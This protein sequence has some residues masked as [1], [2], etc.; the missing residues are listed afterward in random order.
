MAA[1]LEAAI[2]HHFADP[3]LLEA[4]LT[5]A[6]TGAGV[7]YERLEFLGDRVVGLVV[8]RAL[9]EAFPGEAEGALAKRLSALV[10]GPFLAGLAEKLGL[11]AHM[12]FSNAEA[13]SGGAGNPGIMADAFEA[14]VGALYLDAGMEAARALVLRAMGDAIQ[15]GREPPQ[16]PKT[17]L[18]EWAQGRGLPLPDY[19]VVETSG[20][21]HAPVFIVRVT[22]RGH[23]GEAQADGPSRQ[24]AEKAAA[25]AFSERYLPH[26]R[27][28]Q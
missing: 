18:Q 8:A 23:G 27:M 22:V 28:K 6:S 26:K 2:G 12:R 19:V 20:P 13:A 14:L 24:A 9:Y 17:A 5:H 16:H 25:Q 1:E 4:A 11:G 7:S 3:T 10:S 21:D 15:E